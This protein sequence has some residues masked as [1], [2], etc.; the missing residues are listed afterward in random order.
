MQIYRDGKTK[1]Y[2][3]LY[4]AEQDPPLAVT[5]LIDSL[6][7]QTPGLVTMARVRTE[8]GKAGFSKILNSLDSTIFTLSI[9]QKETE[10]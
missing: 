1:R 6:I 4:V 2:R 10:N 7:M 5:R 8:K 9:L 3:E